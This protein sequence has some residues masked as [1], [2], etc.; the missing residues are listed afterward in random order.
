MCKSVGG[1]KP[2]NATVNVNEGLNQ[3]PTKSPRLG[4]CL[5]S[6]L[7]S[8]NLGILY[9]TARIQLATGVKQILDA[10]IRGSSLAN[11]KLQNLYSILISYP[12]LPV[13]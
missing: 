13:A 5:P 6:L 9:V 11:R 2:R 12:I 10:L 4:T 1:Y 8:G 7:F 3:P